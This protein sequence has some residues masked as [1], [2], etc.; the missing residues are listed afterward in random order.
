VVDASAGIYTA[1]QGSA[2]NR[3]FTIEWRNVA[4]ADDPSKRVRFEI[5]LHESGRI[6]LQ[7]ADIAADSQE[8]G[9]SAT[10]GMENAD[11]YVA[12]QYSNDEPVLSNALAIRFTPPVANLLANPGFE[13][14][15]NMDG[16]PDIWSINDNFRHWNDEVRNGQ[17]SGQHQ[18]TTDASYTIQQT[19]A[20][21]T[22]GQ[23][24]SFAGWIN[25]PGN[26]DT[27]SFKLQ[28]QW[29]N[30]SNTVVGTQ[31]IKTYTASTGGWVEAASNALSAPTGATS[32]QIQM[33]VSS[34]S[35]RAYVDDFIFGK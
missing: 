7:Y 26:G 8:R 3:Q 29:L 24:Y 28:V 23:K 32:A 14:D 15:L 20:G 2:P 22:A 35:G 9:G 10:V 34:L 31:E 18:P 12:F 17:D 30:A 21:I 19:V 25:I 6:L 11:S 4:R 5:I 27:F 33:V 1:V 16:Y 13:D